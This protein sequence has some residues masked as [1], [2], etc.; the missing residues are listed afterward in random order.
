MTYRVQRSKNLRGSFQTVLTE[1]PYRRKATWIPRV[2]NFFT[3]KFW[4]DFFE[5]RTFT[6][7]YH[8]SHVQQNDINGSA[9]S[10]NLLCNFLPT[11]TACSHNQPYLKPNWQT[12]FKET[13]A[14][15]FFSAPQRALSGTCHCDVLLCMG[16][17]D[18][19]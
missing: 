5:S 7:S 8:C 2:I 9:L 13:Y 14:L 10:R 15:Q 19:T 17:G 4:H 1:V 6:S 18:R 3:A 12:G 16:C 11:Q